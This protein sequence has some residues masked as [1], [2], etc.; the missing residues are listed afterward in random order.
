MA[1]KIP[2]KSDSFSD[3]MKPKF[4]GGNLTLEFENLESTLIKV[5]VEVSTLIGQ[6]LYDKIC[7][8]TAVTSHEAVAGPPIVIAITTEQADGLNASAKD[9][10]Q[11][12]M[13]H[14]TLYQN[15]IY[16]IAKIGNDGITVKKNNDETTIFKYQEV[17]LSNKLICDAWFWMNNLIKFLNDNA[18]SFTDWKD[19]DQR[20]Q[21]NSIPVKV[22]DFAKFVGVSDEYFFMSAM[23][24][25]REV[26]TECVQSRVKE[27]DKTDKL[28]RAVCYE[29]MARACLRLPYYSLPE[30]VRLDINTEMS[31]DH[32]A[33][34]DLN[35]KEK[36]S[37]Q[38]QTRADGY[39]SSFDN[40]L[41]A[42]QAK[43]PVLNVSSEVYKSKAASK[44]DKFGLVS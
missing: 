10:L 28:S 2:F 32:A 27:P 40:E 13:L 14:F 15:I 20:K 7:D 17:K 39:W 6:A 9:Y 4:S 18:D 16:L 24:L 21:Y 36:I 31:K 41:V 23:W 1:L 30:S 34:S 38:F 29:V 22:A 19:S 42:A 3:E 37:A 43:T 12:A 33:Q 35:I 11:R 25:I 26:W 44:D 8:G 5:G